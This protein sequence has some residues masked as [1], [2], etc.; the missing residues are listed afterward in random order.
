M[1]RKCENPAEFL[2]SLPKYTEEDVSLVQSATAGQFNNVKWHAVR[3]CRLT[4]SNF[5]SI[6]TKVMSSRKKENVDFVPLVSKILGYKS[7]NP[8]VRSLKHG[9][10]MEPEAKI[11]YTNELKKS[12]S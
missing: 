1:V 12:R 11:Q 7:V 5:Y 9:R 4:A 2:N 10:E 3:S 6:H 8:N